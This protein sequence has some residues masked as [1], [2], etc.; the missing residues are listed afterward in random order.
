MSVEIYAVDVRAMNEAVTAALGEGPAHARPRAAKGAGPVEE[1]NP[2]LCNTGGKVAEPDKPASG[3]VA[4]CLDGPSPAMVGVDTFTFSFPES[5]RLDV[6]NL[7]SETLGTSGIYP[8]RVP[9]YDQ[10]IGWQTGAKLAWSEGRTD[11]CLQIKGQDIAYMGPESAMCLLQRLHHRGGKCTRLDIKADDFSRRVVLI[12][13]AHAAG[14]TNR[15]VSGR[16]YLPIRPIK[17]G[18]V[19]GDT[20]TF[21]MRGKL[22]SGIYVRIYDKKLESEGEVD[23]IRFE[24][25]FSAKASDAAVKY[26]LGKAKTL[27]EFMT[28]CAGLLAECIDFRELPQDEETDRHIERR[29]RLAW[30]QGVVDWLGASVKVKVERFKPALQRSLEY[31]AQTFQV[32]LA[33]AVQVIDKQGQDGQSVMRSLM[34]AAIHAGWGKASAREPGAADVGLDVAEMLANV[35][36]QMG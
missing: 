29:P 35:R 11:A 27:E 4:S 13:E 12:D 17:R 18:K 31:M 23:C 24:A 9:H 20:A 6:V 1:N 19:I 2:P 7:V 34:E 8:G 3:I 33:K 15:V 32:K 22:G 16:R 25:E 21:G 28:Q 36:C 26:W 14:A 5:I 30:W 10:C